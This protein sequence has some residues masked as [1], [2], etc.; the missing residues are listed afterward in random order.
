MLLSFVSGVP[1]FELPHHKLSEENF[2]EIV[3]KSA[4]NVAMII[5]ELTVSSG[6]E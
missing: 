2:F 4:R 6:K 5:T 3:K 1:L